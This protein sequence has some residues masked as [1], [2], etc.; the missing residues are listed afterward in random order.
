MTTPIRWGLLATGDITHK[1]L[2]GAALSS[3]IEIVAIGSRSSVRAQ[4]FATTHG[5]PNAHGS[6]DE[7][8]ADPTVDA[9]YVCVPNSL[10]HEWTL[11]AL[12]AGKHVLC[13]KPYTRHPQQVELA[14]DTASA[15]GLVLQEGFMWR[16]T[17]QVRTMLGL[18]PSLGE[19]RLVRA[20]FSYTM[21]DG[22]NINIDPGLDGGSLMDVGCYPVSAARLL[23]GEP[24]RV[25][26]EQVL[27]RGGVDHRFT[28]LLR[29]PGD[30]V[31]LIHS[32]FDANAEYLE[33]VGSHATLRLPDPWHSVTGLLYLDG[34]EIR[35]E[36]ANPYLLELQDMNAAIRG[37]RPALL[38]RSDALGQ[39][40]T[41]EAL[42]RAASA[43]D[44]V[45]L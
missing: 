31:A 36:P 1:M 38:G 12:A 19:V 22:Y 41:I 26:A 27:G 15:A 5:I 42:F 40:R 29:F 33:I 34:K 18:L 17:P 2:A 6:Y 28:G 11:K 30:R 9:V 39:A 16:H 24:I 10:H 13:E 4:Q 7:L 45:T 44:V 43:Q 23:L 25:S 20:A 21:D 35:A 3:D 8:L 37:E 32:G 14:W